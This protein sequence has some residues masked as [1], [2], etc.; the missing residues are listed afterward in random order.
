M[1][2]SSEYQPLRDRVQIIDGSELEADHKGAFFCDCYLEQATMQITKISHNTKGV[3]SRM[4]MP[5][6]FFLMICGEIRRYLSGLALQ[7]K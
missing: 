5:G 6:H 2:W 7:H 4:M 1:R 3:G